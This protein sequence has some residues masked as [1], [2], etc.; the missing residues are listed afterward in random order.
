[1]TIADAELEHDQFFAQ[2]GMVYRRGVMEID[3]A[4]N[5]EVLRSYDET[6]ICT[7]GEDAPDGTATQ[8]AYA[9]NRLPKLERKLIEIAG[10]IRSGDEEALNTLADEI[11]ELIVNG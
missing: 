6:H 4:N 9:L 8:I 10:A 1:M 7:E 3:P 11:E 2:E 5:T